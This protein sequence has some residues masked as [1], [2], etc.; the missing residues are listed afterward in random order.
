MQRVSIIGCCGAGKSTL[1]HTLSAISGLP[2]VHLDTEFWGEGWTLPDL[3][4]FR[5]RTTSLYQADRWIIDGHYFSTLDNRLKRSDTVYH[6]DYPTH[7]CLLRALSR[8]FTGF[9]KVRPDCAAGCPERLNLEF[10]LYIIRYRKKFRQRTM[11]LLAEH[12][13]LTVH[14]FKHPRELEAHIKQIS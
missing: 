11:H 12:P 9:G 4:E 1:S 6:L 10:I 3:A 13:H 2:I 8:T 14:S 5:E 7:I